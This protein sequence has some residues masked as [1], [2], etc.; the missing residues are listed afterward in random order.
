MTIQKKNLDI[1]SMFSIHRIIIPAFMLIMVT[2][3]PAIQAYEKGD[4]LLRGGYTNIATQSSNG[5]TV[6]VGDKGNLTAAVSYFISNQWSAEILLGLPFEHDIYLKTG[7]K[8]GTGK[9][10]PPTISLQRHFNL[11]TKLNSYLGIG[12][13]HTFFLSEKTSGLLAGT[14]LDITSST[15]LAIQLGFDYLISPTTR[16]NLDIRKHRINPTAILGSGASAI[17]FDVPLNPITIGISAV[18]KF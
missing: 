12:I 17:K 15:D 8:I 13:N 16:V 14:P 1:K 3:V 9:H 10:L 18:Y 4:I 6:N 2:F 5:T 11:S 7:E